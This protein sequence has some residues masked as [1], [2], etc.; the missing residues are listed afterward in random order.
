ME[1]DADLA[2][3]GPLR[4][5]MT[6]AETTALLHPRP[7]PIRRGDSTQYGFF[8]SA[9]Q[10]EFDA[11]ERLCFAEVFA[12]LQLRWQGQPVIGRRLAELS[13][14]LAATPTFGV[15]GS[16]IRICPDLQLV[17]CCERGRIRSA[18]IFAPD[19]YAG[20]PLEPA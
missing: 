5:G 9:V 6:L 4:L 1:F 15:P 7:E 20:L 10:L 14:L 8:D 19:Y 3:L 11:A 16:E 2:R 12:P 17:L 18:G 13:A